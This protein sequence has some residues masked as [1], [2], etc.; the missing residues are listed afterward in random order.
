MHCPAF[1]ERKLNK[2]GNNTVHKINGTDCVVGLCMVQLYQGKLNMTGWN[3]LQTNGGLSFAIL[4]FSTQ[5]VQSP[6][7]M[8]LCHWLT[9]PLDK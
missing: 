6:N 4:I 1:F 9:H 5:I 7:V 3:W 2:M 8:E